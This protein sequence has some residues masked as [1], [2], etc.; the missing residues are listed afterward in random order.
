[1]SFAPVFAATVLAVG[2]QFS[3]SLAASSSAAISSTPAK[4]AGA[5]VQ[6]TRVE[7]PV[8][9]DKSTLIGSYFA[10]KDAKKPTP[11]V[12]LLHDAG[13][14]RGDLA[15]IAIKLHQKGFA[16]LSIDL[17]AHGESA[18][19]GVRWAELDDAAK[20][21]T[22]VG[23]LRDVKASFQWLGAQPGVHKTNLALFGDRAGCALAARQ[24]SKDENVRS[25][26]LL[27]PPESLWN[28]NLAKEV[29]GLA[30]V[31]TLIAVTKEAK[32]KAESLAQSGQKANNG[33]DFIEIAVFK[34]VSLA[35]VMDKKLPVDIA[36]FLWSK[37]SPKKGE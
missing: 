36:T 20:Q 7:I 5:E 30:G 24:A 14:Q 1:M 27:D 35:P 3:L 37:A 4:V 6:P 31:P 15:E 11:A 2:A 23:A 16:V 10:P 29:E 34:G 19:A 25:L 22:W 12:L 28:F 9:D 13:G 17:R 18:V 33:I 21:T 8:A 32:P 26:A